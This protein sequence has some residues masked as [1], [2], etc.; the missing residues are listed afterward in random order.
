VPFQGFQPLPY[1]FPIKPGL[2]RKMLDRG[3]IV[4]EVAQVS[5]L[6][7]LFLEVH[8]HLPRNISMV[9]LVPV[10][11]PDGGGEFA[12]GV[13]Q[14]PHDRYRAL[15]PSRMGEHVKDD[16]HKGDPERPAQSRLRKD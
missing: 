9:A 13:A 16:E 11:S 3:L 4:S 15:P 10:Q 2:S 5:A 8:D 1:R 14:W 7:H 12:R 6:A